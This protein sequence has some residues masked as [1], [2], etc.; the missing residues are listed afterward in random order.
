M[1][2]FLTIGGATKDIFI[3]Y[4]NEKNMQLSTKTKTNSYILLEEGLKIDVMDIHNATGGGATNSA[5]SLKKLGLEVSC[6]FK[7]GNDKA[8]EFILE[9][10]N[11]IGISTNFVTIS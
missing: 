6:C 1:K 9:E 10:L 8:G 3:N 11:K 2:K 7:I 4:E 5:A